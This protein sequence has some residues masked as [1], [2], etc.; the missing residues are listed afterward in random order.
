MKKNRMKHTLTIL[1]A[2]VFS[3]AICTAAMAQNF[4][5]PN[6]GISPTEITHFNHY[7]DN[8]PGVAQ[9]LAANPGLVNDPQFMAHH[10]GLQNFLAKHPGVRDELH[11]SPGQFMY[12][13][14]HYEWAHGGGPVAAMPGTRDTQVARFDNGY[15][16]EHPEVARQL[17]SNPA[18]ADNPQFL[19]THPGLDS[20]LAR[21]PEV[22]QQ[23]QQHPDRFMSDEWKDHRWDNGYGQGQRPL[24]STDRYLD[25]HPEVE[26]QLNHDPALV[27]NRQYV[28]SHP[29]LHEYLAS[30]PL[31]REEW[32]SH[33]YRYMHHEDHYQ[34]T[35]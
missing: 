35:H 1:A 24:A 12:R 3:G 23:L 11:A 31:A 26:H 27:D 8:H 10:P 5:P 9:G 15:L 30:H 21:H 4:P 16:D 13:E 22:R 25:Q 32:K 18:L 19:A 29:G 2:T 33:P 14:G 7:L 17:G 34:H 6:G 20:Y 28:D